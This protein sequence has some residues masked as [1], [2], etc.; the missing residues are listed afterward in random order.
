M[1]GYI[2]QN[3]PFIRYLLNKICTDFSFSTKKLLVAFY[4]HKQIDYESLRF[5]LTNAW[6]GIM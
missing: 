2:L 3:K 1:Y 4:S 5:Q 6:A